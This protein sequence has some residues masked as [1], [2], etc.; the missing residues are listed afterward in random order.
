MHISIWYMNQMLGLKES[1]SKED[2]VVLELAC[3]SLAAKYDELD[4][5]IP[6][7]KELLKISK[8]GKYICSRKQKRED[9]AVERIK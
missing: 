9:Y 7:L 4:E 2:M 6:L 8:Y 3:I 1:Q 5:R